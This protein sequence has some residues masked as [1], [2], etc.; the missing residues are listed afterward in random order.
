MA[1]KCE[2][3]VINFD[4]SMRLQKTEFD[5]GDML[6][7]RWH[8]T[9][10]DREL[11]IAIH[12]DLAIDGLVRGLSAANN[13]A[14]IQRAP[15]RPQLNV[16]EAV[17]AVPLPLVVPD[18]IPL[19]PGESIGLFVANQ[20]MFAFTAGKMRER[21]APGA[22]TPYYIF[23]RTRELWRTLQV[24]GGASLAGGFGEWLAIQARDIRERYTP[25]PGF[26]TRRQE[27]SATGPAY[28]SIAEAFRLYQPGILYLH[29]V[30][31]QTTVVEET[32]Q[33]D[34]EVLWVSGERLLYR[35]D[36]TLYSA[37]I[38]G[39]QLTNRRK[40]LEQDFVADMHWV[41]YGPASPA[42]LDPPWKRLE[43]IEQRNR[44]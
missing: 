10:V 18:N 30:P 4:S 42:P 22:T 17:P 14:S 6:L 41:C 24:P 39:S 27:H 11:N 32:G 33:G 26:P 19:S 28:D 34:T 44:G 25:S 36:R 40:V 20:S 23:D 2:V 43:G 1:G 9:W 15:D 13:F 31:S 12:Q 38:S 16:S 37:V 8:L 3:V 21:S 7:L 29:H 5:V 35:C